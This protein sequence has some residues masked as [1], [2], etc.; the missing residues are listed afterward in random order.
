[1]VPGDILYVI[2]RWGSNNSLFGNNHCN[3]FNATHWSDFEIS[4]SNIYILHIGMLLH[5]V[6]PFL[7]RSYDP[8]LDITCNPGCIHHWYCQIQNLFKKWF[9]KYINQT[10]PNLGLT[11]CRHCHT[12]L[13]SP[14]N[15]SAVGQSL[16]MNWPTPYIQ[17]DQL[18][19]W[20]Q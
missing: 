7:M 16:C 14:Y 8:I 3:N 11:V 9:Q 20:I 18:M 4:S 15:M 10:N 12:L 5:T 13:V 19:L 17:G 1:M 6:R 2:F